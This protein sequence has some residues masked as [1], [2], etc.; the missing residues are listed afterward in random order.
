M[1]SAFVNKIYSTTSIAFTVAAFFTYLLNNKL[2]LLSPIP[3]LIVYGVCV[4]LRIVLL[5]GKR[6][7]KEL[8]HHFLR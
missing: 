7:I 2:E 5:L 3:S 1:R 4:I 6:A 8:Y